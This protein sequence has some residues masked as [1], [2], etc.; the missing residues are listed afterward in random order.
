MDALCGDGGCLLQSA[1]NDPVN[2]A[3][4]QSVEET[5]KTDTE[6]LKASVAAQ[7]GETAEPVADMGMGQLLNVQA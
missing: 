4:I 3:M 6:L 1:M 7:V 5:M 2:K